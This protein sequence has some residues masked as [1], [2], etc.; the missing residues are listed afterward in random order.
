M[1]ASCGSQDCCG[2]SVIKSH[3]PSKSNTLGVLC[4]LPDF[5]VGK[6]VVGP[7][8]FPEVR[9]L[10]WYNCSPV[11]RLSAQQLYGRANGDLLQEDFCHT[12]RVC[13]SQSPCLHTRSLLTCASAGDTQT[14]KGRSGS[15]SCG[16]HCSFPW[17]L[18]CTRVFFC[19]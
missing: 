17:V 4:P 8:T 1:P 5:Q 18:V 9:E 11:C 10:L 3:W 6:S 7:Q 2:S 14:L 19:R 16:D 15:I 13:C 12:S